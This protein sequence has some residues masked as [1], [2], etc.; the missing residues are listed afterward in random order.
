T[1][2]KIDPAYQA[3]SVVYVPVPFRSLHVTAHLIPAEPPPGYAA[4]VRTEDEV[5]PRRSAAG[6][7]TREVLG[8]AYARANAFTWDWQSYQPPRPNGLGIE[9]IHDLPL[10]ELEPYI[11]WTPFFMTWELAGKYPKILDDEVVGESA[12]ALFADAREML[13]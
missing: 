6:S 8:L 10:A 7:C 3:G 12:R 1:A 11:D 2:V 4:E 9:V 5:I 13:A